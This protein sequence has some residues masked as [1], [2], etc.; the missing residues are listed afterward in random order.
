MRKEGG[1]ND[2]KKE[3]EKRKKNKKSREGKREKEKQN[4]GWIRKW[5]LCNICVAF[6]IEKNG[7]KTKK[8]IISLSPESER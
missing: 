7:R 5:W 1:K 3:K 8:K 6:C 4:V 2:I